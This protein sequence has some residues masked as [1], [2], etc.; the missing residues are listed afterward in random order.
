[1]TR[2]QIVLLLVLIAALPAAGTAGVML[3]TPAKPC[4]VAGDAA[5]RFAD[6]GA[7][8]F[9]V[10]IDNQAAHP[11]LRLQVVDD[12][13]AADFVLV[14]DGDDTATCSGRVERIGIDSGARRPDLVV[15]LSRAPAAHKIYVRSARY[16]ARQAAAL[17]AALW[18]SANV[19]GSVP[20]VAARD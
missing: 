14:D 6:G 4:F 1:M 3:S 18:R 11:D 19:T 13:A 20:E 9:S 12:P 17:F 7:A 10:R 8:D 16:S 5:Y 2:K 15:A